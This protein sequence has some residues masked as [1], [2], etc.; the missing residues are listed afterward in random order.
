MTT[1]TLGKTPSGEKT[2]TRDGK[3][4]KGIPKE[5]ID[6]ITQSERERDRKDANEV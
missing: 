4:Y 1:V 6:K 3:T 2:I 5:V